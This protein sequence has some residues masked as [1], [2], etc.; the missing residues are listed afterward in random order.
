MDHQIEGPP[1]MVIESESVPDIVRVT[2]TTRLQPGARLRI[3][4][5]IAYGWS[6]QRSR[7]AIHDQVSAALSAAR[8][9][10]WEGLLAVQ[11]AYLDDFWA[12]AAVVLE[13]DPQSQQAV[14]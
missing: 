6:S 4:K 7:S 3:V 5:F 8:L 10:G 1:E 13:G 12:R 9:T 2:I 14:R 11:R